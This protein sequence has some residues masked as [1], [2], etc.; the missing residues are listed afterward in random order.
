[1]EDNTKDKWAKLEEELRRSR[2]EAAKASG[3]QSGQGGSNPFS[4]QE[5]ENTAGQQPLELTEEQRR[6]QQALLE[7][8]EAAGRVGDKLM[9]VSEK[10]GQQFMD[11]SDRVGEK[12]FEK[13]G[14]A[15]EQAKS[16]ARQL[17]E[18]A[19]EM[20]EKAKEEA[21]RDSLDEMMKRAEALGKELEEKVR[22]TRDRFAGTSTKNSDSLL[23]DKDDFFA[24]ARRFA[25]G[26]YGN[27]GGQTKPGSM[28]IRKNPDFQ[29]P[30]KK[31]QVPG[32]EDNDGDGDELIDDAILED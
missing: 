2:E 23:D 32:F 28:E 29:A 9:D 5:P 18:R 15:L 17:L 3:A 7:F 25:E 30:E 14:A 1:M 27:K 11:L 31:G 20:A 21:S 13:G 22:Q 4:G 26:D 6:R 19:N 10:A 8:K 12:L 24:K 16:Y